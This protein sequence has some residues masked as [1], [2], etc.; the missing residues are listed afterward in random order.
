MDADLEKRKISCPCRE[1][2][3][4]PLALQPT[5][6]RYAGSPIPATIP[7]VINTESNVSISVPFD[8]EKTEAKWPTSMS[9]TGVGAR[10]D[11][12]PV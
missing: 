12:E 3:S 2:N 4:D 8:K 5:A 11:L 6:S 1:S 10:I 9:S 7:F